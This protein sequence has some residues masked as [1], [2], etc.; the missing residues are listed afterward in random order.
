MIKPLDY[1]GHLHMRLLLLAVPKGLSVISVACVGALQWSVPHP[2]TCCHFAW[3]RTL[4]LDNVVSLEPYMT[5]N[6]PKTG[7][8]IVSLRI[9]AAVL[10]LPLRNKTCPLTPTP[11]V[12]LTE[13]CHVVAFCM[14]PVLRLFLSGADSSQYCSNGNR[15]ICFQQVGQEQ[16]DGACFLEATSGS[17]WNWSGSI[18]KSNTVHLQRGPPRWLHCL[19]VEIRSE[20]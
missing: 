3:G 20:W 8:F 11:H 12:L 2:S 6:L 13:K 14:C 1:L 5:I 10:K 15:M 16:L 18:P 7:S 4:V 19:L 17:L 9:S